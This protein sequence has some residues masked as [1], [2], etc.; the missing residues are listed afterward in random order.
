[1]KGGIFREGNI[2]DGSNI[3]STTEIVDFKKI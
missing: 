3:D 1:M 2:A